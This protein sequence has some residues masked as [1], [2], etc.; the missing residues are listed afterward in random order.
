VAR[1]VSLELAKVIQLAYAKQLTK[2]I[3]SLSVA[4]LAPESGGSK[5]QH[6]PRF[7]A[8]F[9]LVGQFPVNP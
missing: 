4:N 9:T 5:Q 6:V 2:N 3:A 8:R 1:Y 7:P